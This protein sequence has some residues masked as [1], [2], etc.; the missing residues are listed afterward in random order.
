MRA[1]AFA[2]SSVILTASSPALAQ[3]A[4]DRAAAA[5]DAAVDTGTTFQDGTIND[6]VMRR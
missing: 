4:M 5:A 3:S 1:K 6:V 2:L